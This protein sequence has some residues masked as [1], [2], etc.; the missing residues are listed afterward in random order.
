MNPKAAPDLTLVAIDDDPESL[1]LTAAAL[2]D[3]PLKI[4]T[5]TSARAGL[6]LVRTTHP[7]IVLLDLIMPGMGGMDALERTLQLSPETEVVLVTGHYSTESAV[8]AIRKGAS[9]YLNKPVSIALLRD[10][11]A[12]LRA[13][14]QRRRLA[15]RLDSE[16]LESSQFEGMIG[17]GPAMLEVFDRIRRVAPHFRT[18]LI[19]GATGTG[20]EL[21]AAALHHLCPVSGARFAVSNCSALAETLI[22]SEL[23]G[24]VRG[25]FTGATQDKTGLF[26][27]ANGGVLFLDEIGDVPLQSQSKLLRAIEYGEVQRVGSPAIRRVDVRVIAATNR[28]LRELIEEKQFRGDL[29]YRL[30]A[31]EIRL[32]RLAERREDLPLL[33]RRFVE[34]F[35]EQYGKPIRGL[36]HRALMLLSRYSWPGN[37]RELK[38]VIASAAMMAEGDLIDVRDFPES[39]R[40]EATAAPDDED[41]LPLAEIERRHVL[42][43]MQRTGG[44]KVRAAKILGIHRATLY[45]LLGEAPAEQSD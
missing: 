37:V 20:K 30:A 16:L 8:E 2:R 44:N 32:P 10:R 9:D 19:T 3:E 5:A 34:M 1:K 15:L 42:R 27:Y 23:F 18:A 4:F 17:R 40:A 29:F 26:E 31:V 35:A 11:I 12:R 28:D 45:R 6:D 21:T 33:V 43:V 13:Q 7:D 39:V 14:A 38:S 24:H 22:E 36:T 41:L 25:S